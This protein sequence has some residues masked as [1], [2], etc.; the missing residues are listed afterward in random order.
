MDAYPGVEAEVRE[1]FEHYNAALDQ[2]DVERLN[3]FFW[4]SPQTVR[5]GP[6][7]NLF[8]YGEIAQFRSGRWSA[9]APRRLV[10][11]QITALAPDAAVTSALF[12]RQDSGGYS[13]QTQAWRR[14][15]EGWRIVAAHVSSASAP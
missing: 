11:L 9:G 1:A 3:A 13:R 8:G 12:Q 7:E 6:S 2:G 14:L 15:P 4:N 5:F 10:R